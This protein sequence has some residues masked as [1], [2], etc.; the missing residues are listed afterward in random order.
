M[1]IIMI[2]VII[3]PEYDIKIDDYDTNDS[4]NY[5]SNI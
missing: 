4:H 2:I 1:I 3:L 5:Q